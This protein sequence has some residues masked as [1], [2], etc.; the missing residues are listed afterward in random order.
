MTILLYRYGSICEPAIHEIFTKLG[1]NV[2]EETEEMTNKN[3]SPA[4]CVS[5][6]QKRLE[7]YQPLFVFSINFFPPIAEI[8][9]IYQTLYLCWTVDCPVLELFSRSIQ[10][11]TNRIFLFDHA[12]YEY[13]HPY[14]PE[15]I[16]YL[17]LASYIE[18][19]D[20]ITNQITPTDITRFSHDI[21]FVGSLYS[22]KNPLRNC[23]A[24]TDYIKGYI[25]G[26]V[27]SSLKVY[28]CNFIEEA[29]TPE[30]IQAIK[31]ADPQFF[32]LQNTINDPDYYIAANEYIGSQIAEV[33]RIRTLNTLANY[34]SVDLYTRSD[35]AP[36]QNVNVHNGAQTLTEMPK[37]FH[38]SKINL[39]MTVRSIQTG[40]P[41]RIFDIMGCCG[42]LM[43]NYQTELTDFFEI[44]VDV[45]AYSSIEE[46]VDKCSYYLTHEDARRSIAIHGY[47]KVCEKHTYIKRLAEMIKHL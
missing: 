21:S 17:P 23:T 7:K 47:Q 41:L 19:Y 20:Q 2:I 18:H 45:E 37:I 32:S 11:S 5:L 26:I 10:Y 35:T 13:F 46:L 31:K 15:G 12:Q 40:L 9:H 8:C 38:L 39:N 16:F 28:G 34:F 14:N 42:F 44:G 6:V 4:E 29:I 36:L 3:L 27:E 30:I 1:L 22:E 33:E 24:L 25:T 43:T